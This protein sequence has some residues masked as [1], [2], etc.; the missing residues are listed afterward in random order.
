MTVLFG[1]SILLF[2][3]SL[4][5][6]LILLFRLTHLFRLRLHL[7]SKPS[8]LLGEAFDEERERK[9]LVIYR[10][11]IAANL[12]MAV[13]SASIAFYLSLIHI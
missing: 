13:V 9:V 2:V 7:T 11:I 1:I 5:N 10:G 6:L 4:L 3:I 8:I 12:L